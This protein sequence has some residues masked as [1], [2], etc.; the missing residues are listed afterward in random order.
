[1]KFPFLSKAVKINEPGID[2][3][4]LISSMCLISSILNLSSVK[5]SLN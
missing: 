4:F 5:A 3:D 2:P 1:M